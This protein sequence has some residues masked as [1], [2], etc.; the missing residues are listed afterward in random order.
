MQRASR[1]PRTLSRRALFGA[2]VLLVG[3][4]SREAPNATPEGA[5]TALIEHLRRL[6]GGAAEAKAAFDLLS[7][8]T[9]DNLIERAQR[10]SAASGK[11]IAPEMM[12]AP[13]SFTERFEARQ[14]VSEIRGGY[15]VVRA[16]GLLPEESAEIHCVYEREGWRVHL[17]LPPL[18]P[19]VVRTRDGDPRKGPPPR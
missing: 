16:K 4:C 1:D 9:Q 5:V 7:K 2:A 13:A 10:Y 11:H 6:D 17:D 12:L 15:A 18:P 14:L 8:D 19:E 3:G